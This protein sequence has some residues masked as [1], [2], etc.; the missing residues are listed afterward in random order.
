MT[1]EW[2][3]D[4]LASDLAAHLRAGGGQLTWEN[5]AVGPSGTPR[6]DVYT[7][8]QW[9]YHN[10][11]LLS[12]E[13]KV[14]IADF[15]GDVTS[16]KWQKYLKFSQGVTFAAPHG[17]ITAKDLPDSKCGLIL[18]SDRGWRHVRKPTLSAL[19]VGQEVW[20][21]LLST[22]PNTRMPNYGDAQD[23]SRRWYE[24]RAIREVEERARAAI[25]KRYG[26]AVAVYLR[27]PD[28]AKRIVDAAKEQ[29]QRM[30]KQA[31]DDA[32]LVTAAATDAWHELA[33][34][35]GLKSETS[36]Y[37][38][39]DAVRERAKLLSEQPAIRHLTKTM[40]K[41]RNLLD[42]SRALS[43]MAAE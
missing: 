8:A 40:E 27:A 35:L 10:P 36:H 26:Q 22:A 23:S 24:D 37:K 19:T 32:E 17:M 3:H 16:G 5:M 29:S 21:K 2:G 11:C 34:A 12:Y 20:V 38:M 13:C 14:S 18:R 25:G 4:E 15:R 9:G 6:P 30:L 31:S 1:K 7:M 42:V 28:E 33:L 39:V 43:G 41:M